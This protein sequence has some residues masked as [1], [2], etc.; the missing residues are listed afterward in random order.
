MA[1]NIIKA[2]EVGWKKTFQPANSVS[3]EMTGGKWYFI[4]ETF[5]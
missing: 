4:S 5:Y 3:K 1:E 2:M